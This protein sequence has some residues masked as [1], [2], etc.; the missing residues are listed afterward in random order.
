MIK[1]FHRLFNPHCDHCIEEA[2][3]NKICPTCAVYRSQL[4]LA[5]HEKKLL[6]ETIEKISNPIIE[7]REVLHTEP[8]LPRRSN[9]PA[10]RKI[11]ESESKIAAE[12]LRA[13]RAELKSEKIEDLEKEVGIG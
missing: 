12:K 13:R 9:W 10:E 11:L 5:N 8:I 7:E 4:E 6:L 1:F 3:D 2:R